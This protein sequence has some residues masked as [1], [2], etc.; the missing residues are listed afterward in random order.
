MLPV[1]TYVR[2]L[3]V[4]RKSRDASE[5]RPYQSVTTGRVAA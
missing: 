3:T 5:R 1:T 4:I 2:V